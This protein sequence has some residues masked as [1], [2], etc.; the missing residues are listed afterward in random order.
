MD[1]GDGSSGSGNAIGSKLSKKL[2]VDN[3]RRH[4]MARIVSMFATR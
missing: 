2:D 3:A 4:V 1:V